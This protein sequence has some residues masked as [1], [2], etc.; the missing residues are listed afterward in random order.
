[1]KSESGQFQLSTFELILK[2]SSTR[3][4]VE[5]LLAT[6]TTKRIAALL[7]LFSMS[8]DCFMWKLVI[9]QNSIISSFSRQD[10][11]DRLDTVKLGHQLYRTL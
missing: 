11:R 3:S 1:M 9:Q 8:C 10:E 6:A 7:S 4:L 2:L 5:G